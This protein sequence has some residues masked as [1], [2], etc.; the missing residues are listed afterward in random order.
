MTDKSNVT[1]VIACLA[2]IAL[3]GLASGTYLL[4]VGRDATL[5]FAMGTTAL[6]GLGALLATTSA[7]K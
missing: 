4:A 6:G 2:L 7:P 5:P 1:Y 3:A